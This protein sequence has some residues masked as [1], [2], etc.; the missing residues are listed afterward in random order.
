[1]ELS[2]ATITILPSDASAAGSGGRLSQ[3]TFKVQFNPTEYTINKAVQI[4][5][6]AIPGLDEPILQFVRGQNE[7]LTMDL[8]FDTTISEDADSVEMTHTSSD[9]RDTIADF[10]QLVQVQPDL[11]APP[12]I[13]FSWGSLSFQAIVESIQQ[14]FTLF[15]SQGVPLRA[16]LT[17]TFRKYLTLREQLED[18]PRQSADFSTLYPVQEG[19]TLSGIAAKKY[20]DPRAWRIIA[21]ANNIASPSRLEPGTTLIIPP[22]G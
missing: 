17:V 1:M 2:K 16:T 9:I 12:R 10:L 8:F 14:K 19:E 4:A 7:K 20:R 6:I 3:T 11:H 18:P 22:R 15:N 5:E 13:L 21:D